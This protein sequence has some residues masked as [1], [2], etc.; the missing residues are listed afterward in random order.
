MAIQTMKAVE[1]LSGSQSSV[2]LATQEAAFKFDDVTRGQK[3]SELLKEVRQEEEDSP[4]PAKLQEML[5][6]QQQEGEENKVLSVSQIKEEEPSDQAPNDNT[7]E[8]YDNLLNEES[9]GEPTPEKRTCMLSGE[10]LPV[11]RALVFNSFGP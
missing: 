11:G 2:E 9:K 7:L 3:L 4:S 8:G 1:F 5:S 6:D 10:E